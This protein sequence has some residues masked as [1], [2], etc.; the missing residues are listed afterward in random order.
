MNLYVVGATGVVGR[1]LLKILEEENFDINKIKAFSSF[2]SEGTIINYKDKHLVSLSKVEEFGQKNDVAVLCVDK[3]VSSKLV[4]IL[5]SKGMYVVDCST[6]YRKKNNIPLVA[7]G[8][9][10][11]SIQNNKLI[12]N[13]NCVVMQIILPI[14]LI[15][16]EYTIKRIEVVSFQS[17]SGSGKKGI[18]DYVNKTSNFYPYS[19]N[20][21]CIPLVGD[22]LENGYTSEEDKIDFEIK[23]ILK[24]KDL[25]IS[26]TCVRV[27]IERCHGVS[28][29]IEFDEVVNE[30]SIEK[31]LRNS[32]W[33]KYQK[34]P[35]GEDA[36]D[37]D[38]IYFGRVRKDLYNPKLIHMYIVGDN[39]RRGAATNAYWIVKEIMKK[40]K[41]E[42]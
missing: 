5:L 21:T 6:A 19:I 3:S 23:K 26:A 2:K 34:V 37:N 4:P 12:C 24:N 38:F 33:C 16:K 15:N 13:P 1:Q 32:K 36:I 9:N 7:V 28:L 14:Y 29:S 30:K 31:I 25:E 41:N 27:P 22:L 40:N 17:V 8:V 10:E 35:N 11:E 18:D 39:L 20:K 42:L